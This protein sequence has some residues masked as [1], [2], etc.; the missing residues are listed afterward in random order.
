MRQLV[1]EHNGEYLR[2]TQFIWGVYCNP[3]YANQSN[4]FDTT[5]CIGFSPN[6]QRDI[7]LFDCTV[8]TT[9]L[10]TFT[11]IL[12]DFCFDCGFMAIDYTDDVVLWDTLRY[13][14]VKRKWIII[15]WCVYDPLVM[16][17]DGRWEYEQFIWVFC[18]D[19]PLSGQVFYDEDVDCQKDSTEYGLANWRIRATSSMDTVETLSSFDGSYQMALL[20]SISYE[21]TLTPPNSAWQSCQASWQVMIDDVQPAV[22]LDLGGQVDSLCRN[23][24][25]EIEVP[26]L[27][28]CRENRYLLEYGNEGTELVSN[29]MITL[30]LAEE[31][32]LE[33]ADLPFTD[34]GGGQY[35]LP[36]GD[37]LPG[38]SSFAKLD[39]SVDCDSTQ[40]G[41]V[42][43]VEAEIVPSD[44]C[45]LSG[46][47]GPIIVTRA[48][49]Q[50][51]S[52]ILEIENIG[53]DMQVE[54]EYWVVEDDLILFLKNFQLD[55]LEKTKEVLPA[56]G[57]TYHIIAEQSPTYPLAE[58]SVSGIEG[59]APMGVPV[60]LGYLGQFDLESGAPNTS[61]LCEEIVG[62]FDPND[63]K[64]TP[65]GLGLNHIID[66][67]QILEYTIRFQNVGND[68]AF[69]VRVRDF[70]DAKLDP[71]SIDVVSSSHP[72]EVILVSSDV[73]DFNGV[74]FQFSDIKLVD[75]TTNEPGSHGYIKFR[76]GCQL[77]IEL[78]ERIEN[79]ADIYF[80]FND[81]IRTNTVFHTIGVPLVVSTENALME[82]SVKVS[83]GP[84]PVHSQLILQI[85]EPANDQIEEWRIF[86]L[87]G[88]MLAGKAGVSS[89]RAV[90]DFSERP[91][92]T[93]FLRVTTGRGEQTSFK[94]LKVR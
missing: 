1:V 43:C 11:P 42:L 29:A 53:E 4:P 24:V 85:D 88:R 59:C 66:S 15:D 62:P 17:S 40:L 89:D 36:V 31:M 45:A 44:T 27:R 33:S 70:L 41:Q 72:Y 54:R 82:N 84:N 34:L 13:F 61:V 52:I 9:I 26:K 90:I 60:S 68:T 83:F 55:S 14:V 75:S 76:V 86:D 79:Y 19:G 91:V 39:I 47:Q 64:A 46:Y 2:D 71:G 65:V 30:S 81:P 32:A 93:Y 16:N 67:T 77:P 38:T 22:E 8:D 63:K 3:F 50:T 73:P 87:H 6:W 69:D 74:I 92:G 5:D 25:V 49:C 80:D 35:E 7:Y 37:L 10:D 56:T 12:P 20:D 28:R 23:A 57:S 51:D 94:V 21:V 78:G 48:I 58:Y 18:G